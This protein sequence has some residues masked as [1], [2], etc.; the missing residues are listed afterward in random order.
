MAGPIAGAGAAT[1]TIASL[2]RAVRYSPQNPSTALG[3][4]PS[5]SPPPRPAGTPSTE[6]ATPPKRQPTECDGVRTGPGLQSNTATGPIVLKP[7]AKCSGPIEYER[8][9]MFDEHGDFLLVCYFSPRPVRRPHLRRRPLGPLW[10]LRRL[11]VGPGRRRP[12]PGDAA[13]PDRIQQLRQQLRRQSLPHLPGLHR[14]LLVA[15]ARARGDHA[16][17]E[18]RRRPVCSAP[19][20]EQAAG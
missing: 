16:P 3:P 14:R 1:G 8:Q 12:P 11:A 17:G 15:L 2:E 10:T 4:S 6:A 9:F 20:H 5:I 19:G 13:D 18:G 7:L